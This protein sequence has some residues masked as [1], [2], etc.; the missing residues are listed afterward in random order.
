MNSLLIF[1]NLYRKKFSWFNETFSRVWR[2]YKLLICINYTGWHF[3][4]LGTR[5]YFSEGFWCAESESELRI[6]SSRQVL[7]KSLP[8]PILILNTVFCYIRGWITSR[9]NF[10]SQNSLPSLKV[11]LLSFKTLFKFLTYIFFFWRYRSM[12]LSTL[13]FSWIQ[14]YRKKFVRK[15]EEILRFYV[16]WV[17]KSE[18]ILRI[19][20]SPQVFWIS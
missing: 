1:Y 20:P 8:N 7:E 2:E 16:F 12:K 19:A 11:R 10:F 17:A 5:L 14:P 6:V 3:L 13:P 15:A 9:I 18:S 4:D